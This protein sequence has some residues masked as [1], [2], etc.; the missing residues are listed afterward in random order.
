MSDFTLHSLV[1]LLIA[2][3]ALSIGSFY[4]VKGKHS[5]YQDCVN[6]G[7]SVYADERIICRIEP[8]KD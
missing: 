1:W 5:I 3:V 7:S 4:Y 8:L 2:V 6:Y